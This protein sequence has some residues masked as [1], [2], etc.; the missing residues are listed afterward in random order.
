MMW[1]KLL[2]DSSLC[3]FCCLSINYNFQTFIYVYVFILYIANLFTYHITMLQKY[4]HIMVHTHAH[5][6]YELHKL[7]FKSP[8]LVKGVHVYLYE[9]SLHSTKS[10]L[11][12]R[13]SSIVR[14]AEQL[15]ECAIL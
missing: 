14:E 9:H 13:D 1:D 4:P 6:I 7:K 10:Y 2:Q 3:I 8:G 5:K 11:T 15:N 12:I